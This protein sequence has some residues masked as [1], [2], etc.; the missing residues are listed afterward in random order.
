MG[1]LYANLEFHLTEED[2]DRANDYFERVQF[3]RIKFTE[4]SLPKDLIK[5]IERII[6]MQE[7]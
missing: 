3:H 4:E 1:E 5:E 2:I 6:I 7:I